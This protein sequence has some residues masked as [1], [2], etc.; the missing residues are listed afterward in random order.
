MTDGSF[1]FRGREYK[2][3]FSCS[4]VLLDTELILCV[5][6]AGEE[7]TASNQRHRIAE[8]KLNYSKCQPPSPMIEAKFYDPECSFVLHFDRLTDAAAFRDVICF[9]GYNNTD[10]EEYRRK[11][12]SS[13]CPNSMLMYK[14]ATFV[15]GGE[16]SLPEFGKS[17]LDE[18]AK[19]RHCDEDNGKKK[20]VGLFE[21]ADSCVL[22]S[23]ALSQLGETLKFSHIIDEDG[24]AHEQW[25]FWS[26]EKLWHPTCAPQ[27]LMV[28]IKALESIHSTVVDSCNLTDLESFGQLAV[29]F[30][31]MFRCALDKEELGREQTEGRR[32]AVQACVFE[33][34]NT[35]LK[36]LKKG[37]NDYGATKCFLTALSRMANEDDF[38]RTI[39]APGVDLYAWKNGVQ[40]LSAPFGFGP[41]TPAMRIS[42]PV[43]IELPA[44]GAVSDDK[45]ESLL[46]VF[47]DEVYGHREVT[48]REFDKLAE[49]MIGTPCGIQEAGLCIWL[50][51]NAT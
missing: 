24:K 47:D 43:G 46:K 17:E 51:A 32:K 12:G 14:I 3:D 48:L 33:N 26:P 1:L 45:F 27:I 10:L 23:L 13:K 29:Q 35:M 16:P 49:A 44:A 7:G 31:A 19:Q 20:A 28:S 2:R 15:H 50:C 37:S 39:D 18:T 40:E 36:Q 42:S 9:H 11:F 8:L 5:Y 4:N 21:H 41:A 38:I 30:E 34:G 25:Y 22:A 6:K